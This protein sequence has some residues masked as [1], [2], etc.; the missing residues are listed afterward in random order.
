M[1]CL[2]SHAD[3]SAKRH[4]EVFDPDTADADDQAA[5]HGGCVC[6]KLHLNHGVDDSGWKLNISG[7]ILSEP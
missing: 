7:I 6:L 3:R 1:A 5:G 2:H 4:V